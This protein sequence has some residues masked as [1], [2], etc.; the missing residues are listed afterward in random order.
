MPFDGGQRAPCRT[1]VRDAVTWMR[2]RSDASFNFYSGT[3]CGVMQWLRH[4]H[5]EATLS[6]IQKMYLGDDMTNF[7]MC[8]ASISRRGRHTTFGQLADELERRRG[9]R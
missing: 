1:S 5:P 6:E 2:A 9:K 7:A 8:A 3:N 4:C